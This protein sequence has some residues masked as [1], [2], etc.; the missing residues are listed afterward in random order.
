MMT[1]W[2]QRFTYSKNP[3]A[4]MNYTKSTLS[5]VYKWNNK[6]YMTAHLLTIYFTEHFKPPFRPTAQKGEKKDSFQ[7]TMAH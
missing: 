6:I 3:M 4:L 7:N 2:K 5:L 1:K